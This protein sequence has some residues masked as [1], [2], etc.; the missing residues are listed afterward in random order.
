MLALIC[1]VIKRLS[2][3]TLQ[4]AFPKVS[5]MFYDLLS[6][7]I[8]SNETEP[9]ICKC[10]IGCLSVVLRAQSYRTWTEESTKKIYRGLLSLCIHPKPKVRRA[11][12]RSIC[13]MLGH[14]LVTEAVKDNFEGDNDDFFHPAAKLTAEECLRR[15]EVGQEVNATLHTMVLLKEVLQ[16]AP[17][18]QVE[19]V[20]KATWS[21]MQGKTHPHMTI[22]G[23]R[24]LH[25]LFSARPPQTVL[26]W[27][28]N[29]KLINALYDHRPSVN[30][31]G[32]SVAWLT[33]M[34]EALI[35]LGHLDQPQVTLKNMVK[36]F[37]EAKRGWA[38]DKK[39]VYVAT[40]AAMRAILG[41]CLAPKAEE[42]AK[43][44]RADLDKLISHVVDGLGYQ[45]HSAWG[46]VKFNK[47]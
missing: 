33:V 21:L 14:S 16:Y 34:Q 5:K 18:A 36:F 9:Y 12:Q 28:L 39:A 22:C 46:Q 47:I 41:E 35:N 40:T 27:D 1:M 10:L 6:K 30:D 2:P 45:Y 23:L 13:N 29:A 19:K 15:L 31:P 37:G 42:Y 17:K 20:C 7:Q 11:A 3:D 43:E 4:R 24:L 26:T 8:A 32:P 25:G 44:G 38:S